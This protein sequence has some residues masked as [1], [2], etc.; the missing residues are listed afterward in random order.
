LPKADVKRVEL[1]V[2]ELKR[3][4][5][6]TGYRNLPIYD[7]CFQSNPNGTGKDESF[8]YWEMWVLMLR[9]QAATTLFD[10]ED[11]EEEEFVTDH[12]P[13]WVI[14]EWIELYLEKSKTGYCE[15]PEVDANA[16]SEPTLSNKMPEA[17][18]ERV[19]GMTFRQMAFFQ[20]LNVIEQGT[21]SKP[22]RKP[23][24][25]PKQTTIRK[26]GYALVPEANYSVHY[27]TIM[28]TILVYMAFYFDKDGFRRCLE[29]HYPRKSLQSPQA[30][31]D[32]RMTLED[33]ETSSGP[34]FSTFSLLDGVG[35]NGKLFDYAWATNG[36]YGSFI[37]KHPVPKSKPAKLTPAT[38]A[39]T[40]DTVLGFVDLGRVD[41][42]STVFSKRKQDG[43]RGAKKL[44][45]DKNL[46]ARQRIAADDA[47]NAQYLAKL[48]QQSNGGGG[49]KSLEGTKEP[50]KKM[51][52]AAEIPDNLKL[53]AGFLQRGEELKVKEPIVSYYC[54]YY[55]AKLAIERNLQDKPSQLY[56]M[57]L[58]DSLEKDKEL[59]GTNEAITNDLVGYSHL[60]NFALKIFIS[61]DNEDRAG[62]ASKK[63]ARTF[64]A[65][66]VFLEVLKVFG[67]LDENIAEK[68]KYS[69]YKA[70]DI[71][72]ALKEGRIPDAGPPRNQ[73]TQSDGGDSDVGSPQRPEVTS[74]I[75]SGM[76]SPV[77]TSPVPQMP[78]AP[79][80][81]PK[82]KNE[83]PSTPIDDTPV[84][85]EVDYNIIQSATK[86]SR[87]AI[88][89]L[90]YDDV[91]TA[92][93]NLEKA[94]ALLKPLRR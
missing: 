79:Q 29:R 68:I 7:S 94:L 59:L 66:S 62:H 17:N 2:E 9:A 84:T 53:I 39:L 44:R 22:L 82:I 1:V 51:G 45:H 34:C 30:V 71:M 85:S 64:L 46:A 20:I 36:F 92:I 52:T 49:L 41:L 88:S 6:R 81:P 8:E 16:E 86:H 37:C 18:L 38:V 77:K 14:Y 27:H 54:K 87:F 89:A 80:V 5:A 50:L 23:K 26:L 43:K 32:A 55:A 75:G 73:Q 70:V 12:V 4:H 93:D 61:A 58:L 47:S 56:L 74:N 35:V 91:S 65:A 3:W 40:P 13:A 42:T 72:K 31:E 83:E 90:Q 78:Q 67:D 57:N 11:E 33:F 15:D 63:T 69:R 19:A 48:D 21:F 28:T 10:T 24:A 25:Q 60:E 76:P